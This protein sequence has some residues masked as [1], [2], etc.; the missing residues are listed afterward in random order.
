MS[1]GVAR[2]LRFI[3][4]IGTYMP[5][6]LSNI[7]TVKHMPLLLIHSFAIYLYDT[8]MPITLPF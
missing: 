7:S 3:E 6:Q 1:K 8:F 5:S 2:A 4:I